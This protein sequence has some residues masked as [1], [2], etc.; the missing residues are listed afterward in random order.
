MK[1]FTIPF[2]C[3]LILSS[4]YTCAMMPDNTAATIRNNAHIVTPHQP[5]ISTDSKP[6]TLKLDNNQVIIPAGKTLMMPPDEAKNIITY[7]VNYNGIQ[8]ASKITT[9]NN[10]FILK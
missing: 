5:S 6:Y 9:A 4:S 1:K 3:T 10:E 7:M 8:E 2:Y